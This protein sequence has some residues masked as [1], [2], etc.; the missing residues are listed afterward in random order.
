MVPALHAQAN[1]FD[2]DDDAVRSLRYAAWEA[3]TLFGSTAAPYSRADLDL[4]RQRIESGRVASRSD[5]PS[6]SQSGS[7]LGGWFNGQ[8]S[9]RLSPEALAALRASAAL[10][11]NSAGPWRG[12]DSVGL[13]ASIQADTKLEAYPR[14]FDDG[15]V[16]TP[17]GWSDRAPLVS[18]P[19]ELYALDVFYGRAALELREEHNAIERVVDPVNASNWFE[20][21]DYI[22]YTFP[23]EAFIG[24]EYG[25]L[26]VSFG[27]DKLRW[28]PGA[29]GTLV[30]SDAPDFYDY[31]DAG[32]T[33]DWFSYRFARISI[34]PSLRSTELE[35]LGA[36]AQFESAKNLFLHRYEFLLFDRIALGLVEG[37][38]VGGIEPDLAYANPFLVLH[39]RFAWNATFT[40]GLAGNEFFTAASIL[41]AELRVNPWRYMELYGSFAMN[42]FQT[43]YELDRYAGA[44]DAMPNA[45]AWQAGGEAAYPLLGGWIRA[46]VEYVY[47]NPWMYIRENR[48]NSFTWRRRLASNVVGSDQLTD[49]FLGYHYGPDAKVFYAAAGWDAPGKLSFMAS[50]EYAERGEQNLYTPY[51][52]GDDAVGLVTPT[53]IAELSTILALEASWSPLP[54]LSLYGSLA[55]SSILNASHSSG[56]KA[57]S[58][59]N[60]IGIAVSFPE[61]L[62][63]SR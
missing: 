22:D 21:L 38:M 28:G 45:F 44:A 43:Q 34:D 57:V 1:R 23:F 14:L 51:D 13:G 40:D 5:R 16:P 53:G 32:A 3:G 25:P 56:A 17:W 35:A 31:I 9:G 37:L 27:R 49:A 62:G 11:A 33:G 19:M 58:V 60:L 4:V 18:I 26:S 20:S 8:F 12:V 55:S 48:F 15:N 24:A 63:R 10:S 46:A 39:N 52:E 41:G 30:L 36:G 42:Q 6:A 7:R 61:V 50:L 2:T 29:T 54:G 47:T 59:D